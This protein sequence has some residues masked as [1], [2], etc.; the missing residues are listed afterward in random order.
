M[1]RLHRPRAASARHEVPPRGQLAGERRDL[2]VRR[3]G[4]RQA[5]AAHDRQHA[6][7][8]DQLRDRVGHAVVVEPARE[9]GHQV[10]RRVAPCV[11]VLAM[12]ARV[13][14]LRGAGGLADAIAVEDQPLGRVEPGRVRVEHAVR[15]DR[16]REQ[17]RA[18]GAQVVEQLRIRPAAQDHRAPHVDRG[19]LTRE[20]PQVEPLQDRVGEV[21]ARVQVRAQAGRVVEL[22][23]DGHWGTF[24]RGPRGGGRGHGASPSRASRRRADST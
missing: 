13:Q 22:A 10:A 20:P 5:V 18:P 3:V 2:P 19:Q 15:E 21:A 12:D 4:A 23:R 7:A 9:R 8:G 6:P 11:R 24:Q 16:G 17:H 1:G 14:G